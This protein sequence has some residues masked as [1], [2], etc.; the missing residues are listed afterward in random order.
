MQAIKHIIMVFVHSSSYLF[1][2]RDIKINV[3]VMSKCLILGL[4]VIRSIKT[5]DYDQ[6]Y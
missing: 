1:C 6:T 4:V 2:A 5:S 3:T